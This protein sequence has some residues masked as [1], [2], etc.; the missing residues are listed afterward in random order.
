MK[1]LIL[2][3]LLIS[4]A[5]A[6]EFEA[7]IGQ[8][9]YGHQPSGTWWVADQPPEFHLQGDAFTL[10]ITGKLDRYRLR[11]GYIDMGTASSAAVAMS[12]DGP[13]NPAITPT[14]WPVSHWYGSGW[15]Q[16]IYLTV[17]PE[18]DYVGFT[19][20]PEIG[21]M[22]F[23]PHFQMTIPDWR[24]C[25]TCPAQFLQVTHDARPQ[26]GGMVGFSVGYGRTSL[27]ISRWTAEASGDQ[28][29]AIY[30]GGA[31]N[32]LLRHRF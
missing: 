9:F 15:V 10:G 1:Y 5:H 11:A 26:R 7:S 30:H 14:T 23:Q 12:Y 6:I 29:P 21:L 13:A 3:L 24:P 31:T 17:A 19:F 20:A 22:A 32:V 18:F 2:F 27:L 16:G 25:G 4:S 8:S 28:W